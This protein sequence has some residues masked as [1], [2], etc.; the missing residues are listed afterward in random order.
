MKQA[1]PDIEHEKIRAE[2]EKERKRQEEIERRR[3]IQ[4]EEERK[5]RELEYQKRQQAE[6]EQRKQEA[7]RMENTKKTEQ[8]IFCC[9]HLLI[10]YVSHIINVSFDI[11]N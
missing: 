11:E 9:L 6:A 1:I 2:E 5:K 8:V 4:I 3:L 10:K 7:I